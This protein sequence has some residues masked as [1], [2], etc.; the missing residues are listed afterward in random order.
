M[1]N[2]DKQIINLSKMVTVYGFSQDRLTMRK[3]CLLDIELQEVDGEVNIAMM[4]DPL[5]G[6]ACLH[7]DSLESATLEAETDIEIMKRDDL[8]FTNLEAMESMLTVATFKET[9]VGG[10][11]FVSQDDFYSSQAEFKNYF[12]LKSYD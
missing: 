5:A 7:R 11:W 2:K 10:T 1:V 6:G 12:A 9:G 3:T 8:F 4:A